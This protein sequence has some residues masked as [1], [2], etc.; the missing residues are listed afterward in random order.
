M[1]IIILSTVQ[2][3]SS[4]VFAA[5]EKS[6]PKLCTRNHIV[7][8]TILICTVLF[9]TD[10]SISPISKFSAMHQNPR[11]E[12]LVP[13]TIVSIG[14]RYVLGFQDYWYEHCLFQSLMSLDVAWC[15]LHRGERI[16]DG[17]DPTQLLFSCRRLICLALDI[18]GGGGSGAVEGEGGCA[19]IFIPKPPRSC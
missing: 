15:R 1:K 14:H 5:S 19:F 6:H 17:S 8:I 12:A 2:G 13:C 18:G 16:S 4:Q 7:Y 10:L 3:R 9:V 11:W